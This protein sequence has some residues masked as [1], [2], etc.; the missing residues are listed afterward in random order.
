MQEQNEPHNLTSTI[1]SLICLFQVSYVYFSTL[2]QNSIYRLHNLSA[3][4][5]NGLLLFHHNLCTAD[6]S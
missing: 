1:V 5:N 3:M 4:I 6:D 2:N